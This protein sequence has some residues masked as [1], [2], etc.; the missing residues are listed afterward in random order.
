MAAEGLSAGQVAWHPIPLHGTAGD[1]A[2]SQAVAAQLGAV[3]IG[4]DF[5]IR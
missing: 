5:W 2:A 3:K 1:S 4:S